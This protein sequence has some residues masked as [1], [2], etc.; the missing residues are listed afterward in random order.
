MSE[1]VFRIVVTVAVALAAVAFVIQAAVMTGLYR[2][3][4][5]I[6]E[7]AEPLMDRAAPVIEELR[8]FIAKLPAKVRPGAED[9]AGLGSGRTG[10]PTRGRCAGIGAEDPG[11]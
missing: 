2:A 4:K 6:Q 5:K 7:K 9:R 8:P 3:V 10:V 1:D 11:R